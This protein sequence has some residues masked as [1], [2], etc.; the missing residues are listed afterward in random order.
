[1]SFYLQ[2]ES[3]AG[4]VENLEEMLFHYEVLDRVTRSYANSTR[5]KSFYLHTLFLGP[6]P[7]QPLHPH[8]RDAHSG[9]PLHLQGIAHAAGEG[10][11]DSTL[12][13]RIED[14]QQSGS[15]WVKH[16]G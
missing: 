4:D 9:P 7:P 5:Y 6:P 14:T 8:R 2:I 1:M 10:E 11:E 13:N 3:Q 15:G 16:V 12:R